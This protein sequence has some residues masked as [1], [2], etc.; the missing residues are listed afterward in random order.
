MMALLV[1]H[2]EVRVYFR[3]VVTAIEIWN[4]LQL[5][6]RVLV[7][8]RQLRTLGWV[9]WSSEV[10]RE[11]FL[12]LQSQNKRYSIFGSNLSYQHLIS[13]PIRQSNDWLELM[14][15][16]GFPNCS[17]NIVAPGSF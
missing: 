16:K 5:L 1:F 4:Y 13:E 14:P 3:Q 9:L 11:L 12:F 7:E 6:L 8:V 15:P 10:V 17:Q 2:C